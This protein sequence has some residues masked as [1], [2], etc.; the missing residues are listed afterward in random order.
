MKVDVDVGDANPIRQHPYRLN[1]TK[2]AI[3]QKEVRN[4]LDQ[5]IIEPSDS[6][7]SS[8]CLMVPK[9]GNKF[10]VCADLRQVNQLVKGDSFPLPR[11]DDCIDSIGHA[12]FITTLDLLKG[13]YQI[14][15]TDR[16]KQILTMTTP[17]GLYQYKV[18]PFGL[19]TA[20]AAFQR[21]MNNVLRDVPQVKVY[22]DDVVIFTDSWEDHVQTI[23]LVFDRLQ[24]ANLTVNLA[25]CHFGQAKVTYL[26]HIV[27]GGQ[28]APIDAKVATIVE[29]PQP[30]T[31]KELR[32]FLGMAGYYR[33]FCA[34]FATIAAPLTTL[35][36]KATS[37]KWE[38]KCEN[39]FKMLK[40]MLS[41]HPVL[42]GP[43]FD[44]PFQLAVDAS[45]QGCGSVLF[46]HTESGHEQPVSYFSRKFNKHQVNYS[47]VEKEALGLILS[48]QHYDV[49]LA[50]TQEP[51]TVYTDHNPLTF[52]H[53]MKGTNQRVLRWSLLIQ[54]YNLQI[55]HIKGT[56]N[57]VA[58]ALSR[59]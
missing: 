54:Q 9:P 31:R 59:I 51:V 1:P 4:M 20:P 50:N 55:T 2:Q 46:Q 49:Y 43:R 10:R 3:L 40:G 25:K 23:E 18:M 56:N 5:G 24:H 6:E 58:D 8:P 32:R 52:I 33:R 26:G 57:V 42:A 14:P 53:R 37:F 34:N 19:K 12:K 11:M 27:G 22:L 48:L 13:Y 16:A 15:L 28:I 35:L 21:L 29:F 41:S 45:D 44:K 30:T 38:A 7:W 47:T 36:Q 39:A 17:E